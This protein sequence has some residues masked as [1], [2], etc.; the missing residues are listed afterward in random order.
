M[1]Y[2]SN[3]IDLIS[4]KIDFFSANSPD[5]DECCILQQFIWVFTSCRDFHFTKGKSKL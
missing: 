2:F 5:P 1:L 3:S 4:L